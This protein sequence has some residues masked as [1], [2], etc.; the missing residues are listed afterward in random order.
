[1]VIDASALVDWIVFATESSRFTGATWH[2][3]TLLDYEFVSAIRGLVRSNRISA[4]EGRDAIESFLMLEI[5]R[6]PAGPLVRTMWSYRHDVS[7]YDA[8][9]VSL[10]QALGVSLVTTDLRLAHT[11]RRWCDVIVPG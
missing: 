1:V 10:A 5:N 3:P 8:S 9:Y 6:H 4:S 2:A 11:A 7:A